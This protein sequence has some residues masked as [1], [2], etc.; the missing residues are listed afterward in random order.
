MIYG[1]WSKQ[2]QMATTAIL[3]VNFRKILSEKTEVPG[4]IGFEIQFHLTIL[5]VYLPYEIENTRNIALR[6]A[7]AIEMNC[8]HIEMIDVVVLIHGTIHVRGIALRAVTAV[9][10]GLRPVMEALRAN[11]NGLRPIVKSGLAADL[12]IAI[13]SRR[14]LDMISLTLIPRYTARGKPLTV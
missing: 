3:K 8:H 1:K 5:E 14:K 13:T 7:L 9:V 6:A 12:A 10:M 11:Q 2:I 4:L